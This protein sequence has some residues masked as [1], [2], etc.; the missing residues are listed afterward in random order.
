[1]II[2]CTLK[3]F[4]IL[5]FCC[6]IFVYPLHVSNK[7]VFHCLVL[8]KCSYYTLILD[9]ISTIVELLNYQIRLMLYIFRTILVQPTDSW[10]LNAESKGIR[11]F[12]PVLSHCSRSLGFKELIP[13]FFFFFFLGFRVR[14]SS[15]S[16]PILHLNS[17]S[18][19]LLLHRT[20][21]HQAQQ[22]LSMQSCCDCMWGARLGLWFKLVDSME[23]LWPES[24]QTNSN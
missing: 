19:G 18:L 22:Y 11:Y 5:C 9:F 15:T 16:Y 20:W 23:A 6:L 10:E 14:V 24:P 13:F 17:S 3:L 4:R 21:I 1:M 12:Y 2:L 7:L 8:L